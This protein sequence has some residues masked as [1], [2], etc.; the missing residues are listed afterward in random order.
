MNE[1]PADE[2]WIDEVAIRLNDA[3]RTET[4]SAALHVTAATPMFPKHWGSLTGSPLEASVWLSNLA[5][6]GDWL[7]G[8][9]CFWDSNTRKWVP[10]RDQCVPESLGRVSIRLQHLVAI[11]E[12]YK[13]N[14]AHH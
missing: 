4:G 9:P 11:R 5:R 7:L 2:C 1:S 8:D 14:A 6:D 13:A 3:N 12:Y 10:F